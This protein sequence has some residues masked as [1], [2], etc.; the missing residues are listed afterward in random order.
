MLIRFA[1]PF[2]D[3]NSRIDGQFSFDGPL[4]W[5]STQRFLLSE[6]AWYRSVKPVSRDSLLEETRYSG[7]ELEFV[8]W[9]PTV[10]HKRT[11]CGS[12]FRL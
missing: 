9:Q 8:K 6:S 4:D 3:R 5:I 2:S 12:I 11:N 7:I 1:S 10:Q